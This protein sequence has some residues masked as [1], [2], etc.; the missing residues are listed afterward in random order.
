MHL[1]N[2][3]EEI[4]GYDTGI[5]NIIAPYKE[6]YTYIGEDGN[7]HLC[8]QHFTDL[9]GIPI[10]YLVRDNRKTSMFIE[11]G[12]IGISIFN[13]LMFQHPY[14]AF[15]NIKSLLDKKPEDNKYLPASTMDISIRRD[16]DKLTLDIL[17][18]DIDVDY[19]KEDSEFSLFPDYVDCTSEVKAK[20]DIRSSDIVDKRKYSCRSFIYINLR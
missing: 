11:N 15:F 13:N 5:I 6:A 8:F 16:E 9:G 12:N 2:V 18:S 1:D 14:V 3:M 7:Y 4:P 19:V 17:R 20:C 10:K